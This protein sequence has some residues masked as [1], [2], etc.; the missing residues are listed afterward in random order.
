M[1]WQHVDGVYSEVTSSL[2]DSMCSSL[3]CK[4]DFREFFN[5]KKKKKSVMPR[6]EVKDALC[7]EEHQPK[8]EDKEFC[9]V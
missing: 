2:V 4:Q 1:K 5:R 6:L 7:L 9:F 3:F 8:D